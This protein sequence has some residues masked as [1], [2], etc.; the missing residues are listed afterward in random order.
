MQPHEKILYHALFQQTVVQQATSTNQAT[1]IKT[2]FSM[3]VNDRPCLMAYSEAI[4]ILWQFL[5]EIFPDF[6]MLTAMISSCT[7][8]LL[9]KK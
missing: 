6:E 9:I 2:P 1:T 8:T 7:Q 4:A 3:Q 5:S